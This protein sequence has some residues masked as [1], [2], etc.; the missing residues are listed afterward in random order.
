MP[1]PQEGGNIINIREG[2]VS[3][4]VASTVKESHIKLNSES[5]IKMNS[6]P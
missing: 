1:F 5:H 2:S 3:R 4:D 6:V